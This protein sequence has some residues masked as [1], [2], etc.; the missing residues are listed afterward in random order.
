M[1]NYVGEWRDDTV[2]YILLHLDLLDK[3]IENY[4]YND[5]VFP[6]YIEL[7]QAKSTA[8]VALSNIGG[9]KELD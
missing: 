5:S 7:L 4:Q 2:N 9:L 3:E 8:L 6:R 1:K